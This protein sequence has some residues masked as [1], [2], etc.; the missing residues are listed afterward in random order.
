VHDGGWRERRMKDE[1]H[2]PALRFGQ[3]YGEVTMGGMAVS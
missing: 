3:Y 1:R 2:F